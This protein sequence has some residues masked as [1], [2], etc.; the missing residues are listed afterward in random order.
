MDTN[1]IRSVSFLLRLWQVEA[2]GYLVWRVSLESSQTGD[3]WGF[4]NVDAL[5]DLLS[6]WTAP[7]T[8]GAGSA[9]LAARCGSLGTPEKRS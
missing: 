1:G 4:A 5:F 2:N 7:T 9:G 6:R 8:T 3:R